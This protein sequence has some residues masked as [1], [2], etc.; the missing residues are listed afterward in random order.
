[1]EKEK[2]SASAIAV[3][4]L[5]IL[6]ILSTGYIVYLVTSN[7]SN[8]S[9]N[10]TNNNAANDNNVETEKEE[11][12]VNNL[13][14]NQKK[15]KELLDN[16]S[17]NSSVKKVGVSTY[18]EVNGSPFANTKETTQDL[19]V[20]IDDLTNKL[21]DNNSVEE[22]PEGIGF[23]YLDSIYIY[24]MDSNNQSKQLVILKNTNNFIVLDYHDNKKLDN[25]FYVNTSTSLFDYIEQKYFN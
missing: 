5:S 6:L 1:M 4:I 21:S 2:V 7:S 10:I 17:Q 14:V 25:S 9:N 13:S 15:L 19:D 18:R 8:N 24:Y 16:I 20:L 3:V 11:P 23:Q 12:N 22:L